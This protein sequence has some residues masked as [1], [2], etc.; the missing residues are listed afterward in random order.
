MRNEVEEANDDDQPFDDHLDGCDALD[1][2]SASSSGCSSS[3]MSLVS[4]SDDASPSSEHSWNRFKHLHRYL[5]YSRYETSNR[6]KRAFETMLKDETDNTRWLM[7]RVTKF[8]NVVT[9]YRMDLTQAERQRLDTLTRLFVYVSSS[10][11]DISATLYWHAML[12]F[13]WFRLMTLFPI[14]HDADVMNFVWMPKRNLVR[15]FA[16]RDDMYDQIRISRTSSALQRVE[17]VASDTIDIDVI[18]ST[19]APE[20]FAFTDGSSNALSHK[21][22]PPNVGV[23]VILRNSVNDNALGCCERRRVAASVRNNDDGLT[24]TTVVAEDSSTTMT[25]EQRRV[26]DAI[27]LILDNTSGDYAT[28]AP[29]ARAKQQLLRLAESLCET[30]PRFFTATTFPPVLNGTKRILVDG[31]AGAGKTFMLSE[32]LRRFNSVRYLVKK[33]SF[34]DA[35]NKRFQ[36][37]HLHAQTIDSF[38]M[39]HMNIR[40]LPTWLQQ[41]TSNLDDLKRRLRDK[42]IPRNDNELV[43]IDE[44]S[45][46]ERSLA[47]LL[48][49]ALRERLVVLVG[50]C[51]QQPAI[52]DTTDQP[53]RT[54]LN[55]RNV[56]F[57]YDNVRTQDIKLLQRL[58]RFSSRSEDV[59]FQALR[60]LPSKRSIDMSEF[61]V[62]FRD[63]GLTAR[64]LRLLP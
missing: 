22:R 6:V 37:D 31:V 42:P 48:D 29:D 41:K 44:Y 26:L 3:G 62:A 21:S 60:G 33:R 46:I 45:L 52:G 25:F 14:E 28:P 36:R 38:L 32:L 57:M 30:P 5:F 18:Q 17:I 55:Y 9:R 7:N 64:T 56:C 54:M 12:F 58:S 40:S 51:N 24:A 1:D 11:S 13:Q 4:A 59:R 16:S 20:P 43:F 19:D 49:V 8:M 61:F 35:T 63:F 23:D 50:D 34:V 2:G 27:S 15:I 53:V 39:R 47:E 10:A